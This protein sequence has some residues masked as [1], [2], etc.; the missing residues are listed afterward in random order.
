MST[1][2]TVPAPAF[3]PRDL[4]QAFGR[5]ATGVT[6]VTALCEG[7]RKIG[8][9]ANSFASVSLDPPLVSWNYRRASPNLDALLACGHFVVHVLAEEQRELSQRMAQPA[10]DKFAG[11]ALGSG[12]RGAPRLPGALATFECELWRTVDAGDHVI[13]LGRVVHYDHAEGQ[14]LVFVN[15][16]YAQ[17]TALDSHA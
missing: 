2:S 8:F 3:D 10:D 15:G 16:R 5:F 7:G 1:L 12:Y 14:P 11:I 9:T 13:F 4:R 17:R 6:V